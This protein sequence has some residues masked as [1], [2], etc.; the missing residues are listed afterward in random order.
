LSLRGE[1]E[2]ISKTSGIA[3]HLSGARND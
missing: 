2:A 1:A 3:T